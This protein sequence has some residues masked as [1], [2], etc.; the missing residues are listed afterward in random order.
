MYAAQGALIE[1]VSGFSWE[2]MISDS[3]LKPLGMLL[4]KVTTKDMLS[5]YDYAKAYHLNEKDKKVIEVPHYRFQGME[6]AGSISSNA[7]D[8]AQWLKLWINNGESNSKKILSSEYISDATKIHMA[9][10]NPI[11]LGQKFDVHTFGYGLGWMIRMY[12]GKMQIE[13]GGNIDGFSTTVSYFPFDS[14]GIFV[15]VNQ[16][17]SAA[18]NIIRNIIADRLLKVKK[19]YWLTELAP[20]LNAQDTTTT[21]DL[22]QIKGTSLTHGIESYT[23]SYENIGYGTHVIDLIKDTLTWKAGIQT[24]KLLHYHY[25]T[26]K[27][28]DS[29]TKSDNEGL[30]LNFRINAAGKISGFDIPLE[31]T[32]TTPIFFKKIAG[33]DAK[34]DGKMDHFVGIYT[35]QG[36]EVKISLHDNHLKMS[37]PG[38]PEYTLE[39]ESNNVFLLKGIEGFSVHFEVVNGKVTA[40]NSVQPNGTFRMTRKDL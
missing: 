28:V 7:I 38:Q 27:I 3:L 13:H 34:V 32:S 21:H 26:F 14:I 25:N 31:Q 39:R 18:A 15:S 6:P 8:M 29:L 12:K 30:K 35:L 19:T 24:Y 11:S 22:M 4:T 10:G 36:I 9:M 23:G 40:L 33:N 17:G 16:G 2:K 5:S 37:V 20:D 1:E